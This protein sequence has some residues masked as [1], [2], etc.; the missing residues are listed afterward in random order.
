M[1][2]LVQKAAKRL[3]KKDP[4]KLR[5]QGEVCPQC[6]NA[7]RDSARFC[8]GCGFPLQ[9][10]AA[11]GPQPLLN[12]EV[13]HL[14][15]L[16][17]D[18]V[19][20]TEKVA[21]RSPDEAHA[22][23]TPAVDA[24]IESVRAFDGTVNRELGDGIMALFGA[25]VSQEDH[26]VRACCAALRMHEAAAALRPA[27]RLRVGIASGP[28]LL[29]TLGAVVPGA[30]LAFGPTL[31]VAA[32]LQAL[33]RPGATL[34]AASTQA[35][36]GPTVDLVTLGPQALRGL[37]VEQNVFE[38][39][40]VRQSDLRFS[41]SVA[42]GLSPLV[43]RE[44]ELGALAEFARIVRTRTPVA[45]TITGE[46]GSG[47]SRLAWEFA[48]L[49]QSD[50]W[51][52]IRV[53]ALSYGRD[54]PYQLITGLLRSCLDIGLLDDP[55]KS[56]GRVRARLA[57]LED[58]AV[59]AAALLSTLGL[60]LGKELATWERL[61]PLN[62]RDALRDSVSA[63]IGLAAQGRPT[64]LLLEDLQWADEESLQLLDSLPAADCQLFLLCTQRPDFDP[65]WSKLLPNV[66][67]LRPLSQESML[68]LVEKAF[69]AITSTALRQRLAD[70]AAG[71]P[72]FL[73]ELARDAL[74]SNALADPGQDVQP[75]RIPPTVQSVVA[76]RI[77]RLPAEH[78]ALLV[79]ASAFGNRLPL[80]ALRRLFADRPETSFQACLDA[81]GEAGMLRL[82]QW[83]PDIHFSH[84][85]VQ[86]V[87]YGA[88]P[89]VQRIELH[90]KIA[91]T[92]REIDL[93]NH[94]EHVETLVYH[95]ARGEVWEEL[96]S[97][98]RAAGRR[99]LSRSAYVAAGR[100]FKQAI[101]ACEHLPRS[102]DL[103]A[104]EIDL[105]FELRTALFPTAAEQSLENSTQAELLAR[106]LSDR[107]RL[108]WATAYVARDLQLVGRPKAS[109]EIAARALELAAGDEELTITARYFAAQAGYSTGEYGMVVATLRELLA[110]LERGDLG[111]CIGTP[112]PSVVFYRVWLI[113]ALARMGRIAE[114]EATAGEIRRLAD[115]S[116][117]PL[118]RTLAHLSEGFALT[119]AG[120]LAEAEVT[121]R[122]SLSLCWQ[123][124]FFAW[125]TNILSCLG[126][127]LSRLGRLEEAVD[128]LEQAVERS[129]KSS[130][131]VN[132]ANEL[133]WLAEAHRLAGRPGEAV[134][135]AEHGIEIA[136][137][138]EERGNEG[139]AAFAL[140]EALADLGSVAASKAQ[141]QE[142]ARLAEEV[143]AALLARECRARL[144]TLDNS[145]D[146]ST[147]NRV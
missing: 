58:S 97:A 143:G 113:W 129:R 101:E 135:C 111:A 87:A 112:G 43:G 47:K 52:L 71:N 65:G 17:G 131:R 15:V 116:G 118:C 106:R 98:A 20:S 11:A 64:L 136:R 50:G 25:P 22:I 60:P 44:H 2:R 84:A 61:D 79:T 117:L 38:L 8:D 28:V 63:L 69:P 33:A 57:E 32:R 121:L 132:H 26:A 16:F 21:G 5:S 45:V 4:P 141:Y 144:A 104:T 35:L 82:F 125:S 31:H 115:E 110:K 80:K 36:A 107:R 96:V 48:R 100:F 40:G 9:S 3:A 81:L 34:C 89:R 92:L 70:R 114:A 147:N 142:A 72:F 14:S 41:Q 90:K 94:S 66:L 68:R 99:A 59:F 10:G 42:R 109:M 105:R 24:M 85:L 93:D 39:T 53:E 120:R 78:K 123:G 122:V 7:N 119:F 133:A 74:D 128:L 86:E 138:Y 6:G 91:S 37:G 27:F 13:K 124:E 76:A 46:A 19:G 140:A 1:T 137:V 23:L 134:R 127:V 55:H 77:D 145:A 103:L 67:V 18:V 73:E 130:M 51:D 95:A 29:S 30:Y 146:P 49:R 62:R 88:L 126:H 102:D 56:A 75:I 54:A 12:G 108:G 83:N 139:L